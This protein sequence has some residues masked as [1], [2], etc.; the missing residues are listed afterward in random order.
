MTKIFTPLRVGLLVLAAGAILFGALTFV[1]KGG[2]GEK[3]SILVYAYFRDA[4][5]LGPKSRVQIAGIQV[6]EIV[7]IQLEG[8]RAKVVL[9]IRRDV[10]LREDASLAKRSE[11]LL[12]D[13]LLD[14][15]PGTPAAPPMEDG[16]E[17][18]RVLDQQGMEQLMGSLT[19]IAAD[20][21]EVT[22]A[23]RIALGG[24][25]GAASLQAIVGNLELISHHMNRTMADGEVRLAAILRNVELVTDQARNLT[26]GDDAQLARIMEDLEHITR[27]TREVMGTVRQAVSGADGGELD[28]GMASVKQSLQRLD[29]ALANVEEVT[30][31]VRDGEGT[32]G[33]LVSD[34]RLGQKLG[35]TVEDVADLASR[36]TQMQVEV[37]IRS[38]YL[39]S[40]GAAKNF[41][42]LRLIPKPDKYY[43]LEL[44]DDP[45]GETQTV[46]V[47]SNPPSDGEPATQVQR[48]NRETIKIS[49]QFAKRYYFSTLR[50]G[51]IENTGGVGADLHFL[52]DAVALK[53]DAFNFT[54]QALRYPRLRATL[55]I[56]ALDHLFVT[57]GVDD[58][59]NRQVRDSV[60]NQLVAGRDFF[61]GAGV[62]FTDDDLKVLVPVVPIP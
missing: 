25:K 31:K 50:F 2:L 1:R 62:F 34:E 32:L 37:G 59:L 9:R 43:L 51:I 48:I 57:A 13:Y 3:E 29:N 5:G 49:A 45:R 55:R 7:D 4:S 23:L 26:A 39:L 24:E 16:G 61:V 20:V 53:L 41:L 27:D 14:L 21:Q 15:N 60:T 58:A 30:R 12:G 28:D 10:D 35:E 40:Q 46:I 17:I 42:Q 19:T 52:D 47:T 38:D 18:K 44:V 33:K 22:H 8:L 36:L 11:S 54:V 56:Q 6:G